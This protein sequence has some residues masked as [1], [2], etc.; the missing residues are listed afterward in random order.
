[1]GEQKQKQGRNGLWFLYK[2]GPRS[3]GIILE[4]EMGVKS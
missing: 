4:T 1:M 2:L 3:D